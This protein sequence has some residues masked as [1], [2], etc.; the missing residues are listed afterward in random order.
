MID[1]FYRAFEDKFRGS[2]ELIKSRLNA[3]ISF[4]L[5]FKELY[6]NP[7]AIDLGCGRGEWLELLKEQGFDAQGVDLDEGM[8]TA[9]IERGLKVQLAD[10][11]TVLRSLPNESQTI[12]SAFH[13]V[14]H[15]PFSDLQILIQEALRV[16]KPAGL[17]IMETPNP[18]N[19]VVATN[20]FYLDPTHT[21]PIPPQLLSFLPEYY[22]N[23]K[24]TQIFLHLQH[25]LP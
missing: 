1:P 20:N 11:L 6:E 19:I 18:E 7:Q 15:I 21:R 24:D 5:P 17:L 2:R 23:L 16:L 9:C 4:I 22:K 8:L 25:L 13:L 10:A 14:E 3:Y 12:V